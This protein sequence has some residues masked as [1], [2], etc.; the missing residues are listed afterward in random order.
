MK[1]I[2]RALKKGTHPSHLFIHSSPPRCPKKL[3][4]TGIVGEA[5]KTTAPPTSPK[6]RKRG[7]T[8][9]DEPDSTQVAKQHLSVREGGDIDLGVLDEEAF[10][11]VIAS[12]EQPAISPLE[13]IE[14]VKD[15]VEE[16]DEEEGAEVTDDVTY[17]PSGVPDGADP[18]WSLRMTC[19]PVLDIFVCTHHKK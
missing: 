5:A 7:R 4:L 8:A 12:G 16:A 14:P 13:H 1:A 10:A 9:V 3:Q 17:R 2:S 6:T 11:R 19:L 15:V 18:I